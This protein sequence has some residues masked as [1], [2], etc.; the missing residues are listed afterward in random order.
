MPEN[1]GSTHWD[2]VA[3]NWKICGCCLR[4]YWIGD[5]SLFSKAVLSVTET[6]LTDSPSKAI[7][8]LLSG[9]L[10]TTTFITMAIGTSYSSICFLQHILP[11]SFIPQ[12]RFLISGFLGGLWAFVDRK[13]GR[14]RFLYA[15]RLSIQSGWN[16]AVKRKLVKP[17]KYGL[18]SPLRANQL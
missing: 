5:L 15:A 3:K 17:V 1:V 7:L 9:L 8:E 10:R 6:P 11:S 4:P 14:G 2:T 13:K 16:V 18:S 12:S